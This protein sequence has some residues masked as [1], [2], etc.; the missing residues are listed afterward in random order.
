MIF[1][2][3]FI[4]KGKKSGLILTGYPDTS[5]EKEAKIK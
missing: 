2:N 5:K 3:Q 1:V 4:C